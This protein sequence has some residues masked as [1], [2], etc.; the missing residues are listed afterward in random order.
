M[1]KVAF[2]LG[3][4][5]F[6]WYGMTIAVAVLAA[7]AVVFWQLRLFR[8]PLLPLV[9]L[10][11]YG[12]PAGIVCAR[13]FYC[14]ANWGLYRNHPLESLYIWQGGLSIAG[15]MTG[16]IAVLYSYV[17]ANNLSFWHWTDLLAPGLAIGQAVGQWANLISQEAF[18]RPVNS[19][20]GVYLDYALRPAGYEQYD[21][22][23]PVFGYESAWNMVLFL[24][25]AV[26][27]IG[28]RK[29]KWLQPGSL[30]LLY[31]GFY[32]LGH[33]FLTGL[34]FDSDPVSVLSVQAVS[35]A[36]AAAAFLFF[37]RV[38]RRAAAAKRAA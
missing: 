17:R 37:I 12:V 25:L 24:V 7:F 10:T 8:D 23:Q 26:L 29:Y 4:F 35:A 14:L 15:A 5:V 1:C 19:S 38:N 32:S 13:I 20:W 11:L 21:Y 34:R 30:F 31:V 16:F 9:D 28:Q 33:F 6:Y 2:S 22:F 3:P 18:G 27:A 36:T